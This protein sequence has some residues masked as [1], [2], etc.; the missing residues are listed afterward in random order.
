MERHEKYGK[1]VILPDMR[2]QTIPMAIIPMG[3][4]E[5]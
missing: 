4:E 2:K 3:T 5:F 1:E